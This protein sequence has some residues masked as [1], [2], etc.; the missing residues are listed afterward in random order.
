MN[1]II[2]FSFILLLFALFYRRVSEDCQPVFCPDREPGVVL[3]LLVLASANLK[4]TNIK[5]MGWHK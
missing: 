4:E 5:G 2:R 1:S 3:P